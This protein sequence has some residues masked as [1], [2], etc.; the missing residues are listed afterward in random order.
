VE[1]VELNSGMKAI[2]ET[3]DDALAEEWL[4]SMEQERSDAG[5]R[6]D[7]QHDRQSDPFDP[8]VPA[9]KRG[10]CLSQNRASAAGII[11]AEAIMGLS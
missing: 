1:A 8:R 7:E 11:F 10:A 3:D 5:K 2:L 9:Q 4:S 6:G